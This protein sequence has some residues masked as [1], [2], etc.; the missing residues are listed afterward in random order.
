MGGWLT[1]ELRGVGA[2]GLLVVGEALVD[3]FAHGGVQTLQLLVFGCYVGG[4]CKAR[5]THTHRD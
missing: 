1:E 2:G 5:Q 3:D 4:A